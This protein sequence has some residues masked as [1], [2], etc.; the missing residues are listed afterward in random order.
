MVPWVYAHPLIAGKHV[1]S[2]RRFHCCR[3]IS[4]RGREA[5]AEMIAAVIASDKLGKI[6]VVKMEMAMARDDHYNS[7]LPYSIKIK[8]YLDLGE[9]SVLVLFVMSWILL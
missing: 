1:L 4:R 3:N 9:Y 7:D 6:K 2:Q 5:I 8:S